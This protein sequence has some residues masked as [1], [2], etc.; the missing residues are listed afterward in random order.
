MNIYIDYLP[1]NDRK[2]TDYL[3][4]KKLANE[5]DELIAF[6]TKKDLI[7]FID[8][9]DLSQVKHISINSHGCPNPACFTRNGLIEDAITYEELVES[10][11][12]TVNGE[13]IILNLVSICQSH[14][15][16]FCLN[17]LDKRF[18]EV[19][20]STN[21]TPCVDA[22]FIIIKDGDFDN[23]VHEKELPLRKIKNLKY[24]V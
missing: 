11:N 21:N 6:D 2:R 7:S 22:S 5:E 23:Y 1:D 9:K 19:W 3:S 13:K 20:V 18:A 8:K 10:L 24:I 15:I 4:V 12:S 14:L 17:R 16:D